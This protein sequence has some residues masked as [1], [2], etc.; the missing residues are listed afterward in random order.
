MGAWKL[1]EFKT[2][3]ADRGLERPLF[4]TKSLAFKFD[5]AK[6]HRDL[7]EEKL[8][9]IDPQKPSLEMLGRYDFE[10]AYEI[11]ALMLTLNS[12][13]D[14]FGQLINACFIGDDPSKV[15]FETLTECHQELIPAKVITMLGSIRGHHLYATIKEYANVSKH[16]H[17]IPGDVHVD[18]GEMPTRVSYETKEFRH[19]QK[20]PRRLT[21]EKASK[22]LS[23]IGESVDKIGD[24]IHKE[25]NKS[26]KL[27]NS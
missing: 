21:P 20:Q 10:I 9:E 25:L 8:G 26:H 24:Q 23:F 12:M 19:R 2:F 3:C 22:C 17:A 27:Y 1:Q 14:V 5:A 13:W 6:Y 15:S 16:L 11:D 18:Y 7:L 4:Y